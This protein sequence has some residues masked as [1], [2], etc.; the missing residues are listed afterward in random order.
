[1]GAAALVLATAVAGAP[2]AGAVAAP[3]GGRGRMLSFAEGSMC[4]DEARTICG[5]GQLPRLTDRDLPA[6]ELRRLRARAVEGTVAVVLP[7]TIAVL[8]AGVRPRVLAGCRL[9]GAYTEL[10]TKPGGGRLWA[11]NRPLLLPG[12]VPPA[13][14]EATHT[15][16]TFAV[17]A[18]GAFAAVLVPLPCPPVS[19]PAPA[20][21]CVGQGATGAERR[22]RA[23]AMM[24]RI[25]PDVIARADPAYVLEV[26]ALAPDDY[27]ALTYA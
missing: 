13:C 15:V 1:P 24:K 21:G 23:L 11:T 10:E 4:D 7:A 9:P 8:R 16:A 25:K 19:D 6:E 18:A 12:E 2:V 14:A 17:G 22:V 27:R 3:A 5:A 20:R 26:Y